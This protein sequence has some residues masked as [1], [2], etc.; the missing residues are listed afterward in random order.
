MKKIISAALLLCT[1]L[2][3]VSCGEVK[4]EY[5][6][7]GLVKKGSNEI[8]NPLPVGFEPCGTGDKYGKFGEFTLYRVVGLDGAEMSEDWITEEYSGSATTVFFKGTVPSFREIA[9][10]VCYV[11]EEDTGVVSIATID[12]GKLIEE[13]VSSLDGEEKALWPRTDI[14]SSYTLKLYSEEFPAVFYSLV[15]CVCDSG[16]YIY[17]RAENNCV[18]VGALLTSYV[19]AE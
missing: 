4:F 14:I 12:D 19:S 6:D 8:Y 3:L 5:T 15:Y 1:L 9:F 10:D 7:G 11:C 17:D 18:G 13:I 2:L 16:N